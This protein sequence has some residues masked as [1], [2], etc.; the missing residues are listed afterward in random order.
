MKLLGERTVPSPVICTSFSP[1]VPLL[2]ILLSTS[3]SL[4]RLSGEK[5]WST[6]TSLE[7]TQLA[8]R[9]DGKSA[10]GGW[11]MMIGKVIATGTVDGEVY[12]WDVHD[13]KRLRRVKLAGG[14]ASGVSCLTWVGEDPTTAVDLKNVPCQI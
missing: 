10:L 6:T 7:F 4:H 13:G 14:T 9:D 2:A 11:V 1:T 8:W 3:L 12:V 5:V